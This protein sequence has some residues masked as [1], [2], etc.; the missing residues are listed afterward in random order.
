MTDRVY[1]LTVILKREIRTDDVEA[2]TGAIQMLKGVHKVE[3][4]PVADSSHYMNKEVI[5]AEFR[6]RLL[7]V[8]DPKMW[9]MFEK[10]GV[11]DD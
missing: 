10:S 5:A 2:I 6:M 11:F 7:K 9:E 4:G 1:S 8:L 3:L